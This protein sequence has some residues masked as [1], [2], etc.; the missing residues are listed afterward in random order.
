MQTDV[1]PT[2]R[3][4]RRNRTWLAA[5]LAAVVA[6]LALSGPA[7]AAS[8]PLGGSSLDPSPTVGAAPQG[9]IMSDG[10]ICNPR[11]GC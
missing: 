5:P 2:T 10:R 1:H 6:G 4:R 8:T 3:R 7:G 9:I 11:W